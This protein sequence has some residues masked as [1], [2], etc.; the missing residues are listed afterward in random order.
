MLSDVSHCSA[1]VLQLV[2]FTQGID[3]SP[4]SSSDERKHHLLAWRP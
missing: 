3:G 4:R 2:E 1:V